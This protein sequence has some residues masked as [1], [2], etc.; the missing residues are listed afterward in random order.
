MIPNVLFVVSRAD[1]AK[2]LEHQSGRVHQPGVGLYTGE[3]GP[4]PHPDRDAAS[5]QHTESLT[6]AQAHQPGWAGLFNSWFSKMTT[7]Q[8]ALKLR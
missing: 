7:N 8:R 1:T 4:V 3:A 6:V 5:S 2:L